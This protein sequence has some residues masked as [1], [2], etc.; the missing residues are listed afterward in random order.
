V[1]TLTVTTNASTW[2]LV[3]AG[4]IPWCKIDKQSATELLLTCEPNIGVRPLASYFYIQAGDKQQQINVVQDIA[5]NPIAL[6]D[7]L[8]KA[9]KNDKAFELFTSLAEQGN[10]E[11]QNRLGYLYELQENYPEAFRWYL[12]SA[13]QGYA[14]AQYNL[15]LLYEYGYGV[16]ASQAEA[17]RWYKKS[18]AQGC[19]EAKERLQLN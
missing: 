3:G 12:K 10:A 16:K 5:H 18:A 8:F 1:A 13:N 9:N 4:A 6:G 11:G 15:G 14:K 19:A 17:K 2:S 7:S